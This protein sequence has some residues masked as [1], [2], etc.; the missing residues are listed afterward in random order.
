MLGRGNSHSGQSGQ[1]LLEYLLF[2]FLVFALLSI[3]YSALRPVQEGFD[4]LLG[5]YID[6]LIDLGELPRAAS[7]SGECEAYVAGGSSRPIFGGGAGSGVNSSNPGSSGSIGSSSNA[8]R[9]SGR[10][11]EDGTA[12]RDGGGSANANAGGTS[13]SGGFGDLS[14][15]R[16]QR[17]GGT[18]SGTAGGDAMN[19][20]DPS[21]RSRTLGARS[22]TGTTVIYRRDRTQQVS[23]S[24]LLE[25]ERRRIARRQAQVQTVASVG[26]TESTQA[27]KKMIVTPPKPVT[28]DE[29]VQSSSFEFGKWIRIL[30]IVVL[31]IALLI[32]IGGQLRAIGKSMD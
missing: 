6:C 15:G 22:Q 17:G 16:G 11:S 14:R 10:E 24:G 31:L 30:M 32:F 8:N 27:S 9:S 12:G 18:R 2:L 7:G 25:S 4:Y 21:S 5:D 26:A 19:E 29:Q 20:N 13:G 23:L 3:L 1:G 28:S